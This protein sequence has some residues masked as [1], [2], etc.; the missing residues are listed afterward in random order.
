MARSWGTHRIHSPA[1]PRATVPALAGWGA[2]QVA[3][4]QPSPAPARRPR[5]GLCGVY[6]GRADVLGTKA[7]ADDDRRDEL[8]R[9]PSD[10]LRNSDR[11]QVT[12]Q[13]GF[14]RVV[15]HEHLTGLNDS[16]RKLTTALHLREIGFG[17]PVFTQWAVEDVRRGDR[18]GDRE[19]DA[20]PTNR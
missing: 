8:Q 10:D 18:V 3:F 20:H 4:G 13:V 7:P 1:I 16:G 14:D 5:C 2:A 17:Q 6:V 15:L 12:V 9:S 19:V 11:R